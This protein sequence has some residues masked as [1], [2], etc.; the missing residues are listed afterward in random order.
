MVATPT[1][2]L[3]GSPVVATLLSIGGVASVAE[4]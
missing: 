4:N 2:K 1:A 3:A